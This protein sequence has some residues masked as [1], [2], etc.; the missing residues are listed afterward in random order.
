MLRRNL[1]RQELVGFF[2]KLAP[3]EVA[4]EACG[5]SHHWGRTLQAL[6]H[7]VRLIPP[8]YVKPFVKRGKNDRNDAE[9]IGEPRQPADRHGA[10]EVGRGAGG[11]DAAVGA[12][13]AGA[14]AHAVGQCAARPCD[15][16]RS[17]GG[18]GRQ[19]PGRAARRDR[20]RPTIPAC[21]RRQRR[22]C[23][24][25]AAR[26]TASRRALA[27]IDAKLMQQHKANAAAGGWPRSRRRA[28][29]RAQLR[30]PGRCERS[31]APAGTS[32]HGSGWCPSRISTGGKTAPRRH[33]PRRRRTLAP[34]AGARRNRRHPTCQ[35]RPAP[36][37]RHGCSNCWTASRASS[38]PS[39]WPTRWPASSGPC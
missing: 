39:L 8:Q 37:P 9:A 33:Q 27:Q 28:D 38:R 30:A 6:G 21:R 36:L 24:C 35:A 13:A 10:G 26:S 12:R 20:R 11:G 25:S 2:E 16:V 22:L 5:G 31:S 3:V 1:R 34:A 15:R 18:P 17:G 29:W 4:L 14:P 19:R 23:S 7:R 32:P